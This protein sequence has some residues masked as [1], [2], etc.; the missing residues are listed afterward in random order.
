MTKITHQKARALL[1]VAADNSLMPVDRVAL[2]AHLIACQECRAY[3]D[4]MAGLEDTLRKALHRRWDRFRPKLNLQTIKNP[5]RAKLV[6]G[7]L[8]NQTHA[9]GKVTIMAALLLGFIIFINLAGIQGPIANEKTP[10]ALP[11]PNNFTTTFTTLS[12][13]SADSTS[14]N[15]TSLTCKLVTY[16]VRE[17]DTLESIAVRH[18]ITKEDILAYNDQ[19]ANLAANTV[20]TGMELIIPQ[21][22]ETPARTASLSGKELTLTPI[23][24]TIFP[25]RPE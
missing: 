20:F 14:I 17:N 8:F 19:D 5:S 13:L 15:S 9:L 25:D 18:G 10:T 1:E 11:T 4:R 7:S 22:K 12:T 21:C 24:G 2:N 16:V 6:W 3:A 23:D